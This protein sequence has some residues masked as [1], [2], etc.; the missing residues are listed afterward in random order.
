MSSRT[1]GCTEHVRSLLC[2]TFPKDFGT[3]KTSLDEKHEG[4][5]TGGCG[6][7][8]HSGVDMVTASK[9]VLRFVNR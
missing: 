7:T 1:M 8:C 4:C 3:S 6:K 5:V 2:V 9:K